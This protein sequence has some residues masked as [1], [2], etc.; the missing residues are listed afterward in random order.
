MLERLSPNDTCMVI[1]CRFGD[2][3]IRNLGR[4]VAVLRQLDGDM[5]LCKPLKPGFVGLDEAG[6]VVLRRTWLM[7]TGGPH[8]GQA[9][10][11]PLVLMP[12]SGGTAA[13]PQEAFA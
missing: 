3:T 6:N 7:K 10:R 4:M 11:V 1:G 12:S 2:R 5:W 8:G 13:K 9:A